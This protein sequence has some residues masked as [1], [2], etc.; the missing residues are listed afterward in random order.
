M[1]VTFNDIASIASSLRFVR[2][3]EATQDS[4]SPGVVLV[5]LKL[6]PWLDAAERAIVAGEVAEALKERGPMG[7]AYEVKLA[8]EAS[9]R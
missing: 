6:A 5:R 3:A 2:E 4:A 7:F 1:P 8:P 9:A